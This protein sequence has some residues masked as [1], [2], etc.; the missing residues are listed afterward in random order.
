VTRRLHGPISSSLVPPA[1]SRPLKAA[2]VRGPHQLLD[3]G[4]FAR[5][6][7]FSIRGSQLNDAGAA[8]GATISAAILVGLF[9]TT[10]SA[11]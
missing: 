10:I 8:M 9:P 5:R 6:C 4:P 3:L 2:P 11:M 1:C 7:Y